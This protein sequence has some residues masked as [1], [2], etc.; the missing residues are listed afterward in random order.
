ME[1]VFIIVVLF[2]K[3]WRY[4]FHGLEAFFIFAKTH[5]TTGAHIHAHTL[6][7]MDACT[8]TLTHEQLRDTEPTDQVLEID[9][10]KHVPRYRRERRLP[11]KN[12]PQVLGFSYRLDCGG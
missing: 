12:I 9:E 8:H 1:F 11:L 10:V 2:D 4:I 5:Y 3:R 7:P 6:T